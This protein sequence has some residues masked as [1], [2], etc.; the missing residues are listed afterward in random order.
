M[1]NYAQ[2]NV[3]PTLSELL[4]DP[5]VDLV[6]ERDKISRSELNELIG[7]VRKDLRRSRE[8]GSDGY[9]PWIGRGTAHRT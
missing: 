5:I 4:G 6:L 7:E 2:A 3:E 8:Q 9:W 1:K